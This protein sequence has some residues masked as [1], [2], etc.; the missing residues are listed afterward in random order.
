MKKI[1]LFLVLI[2]G[3]FGLNGCSDE[4]ANNRIVI[5][6][7]TGFTSIAPDS[8]IAAATKEVLRNLNAGL[9]RF[10]SEKNKLVPGLAKEYH[11]ENNGQRYIFVLRDN[12]TFHNGEKITSK[13]VKYSF[14]RIAGVTTGKPIVGDW[15]MN[16][17][18]VDIIDDKTV[19]INIKPGEEKSSDIYDL[20]DVAIIPAGSKEEDLEKHPVGAGPYK[21][22]EY[23]PGQKLVLEAF[24]NYYLGKPEIKEVE[25]RVYKEG[26]SRLMAFKSGDIDVLPL[27]FETEKELQN[28]KD[29]EIVSGLQNDVTLLYLNN[30]LEIFKNKKVRE[31]IWRSIDVDRILSGISLK[32]STKLG[33][34]MS[35]ALMEYYKKGLENKYPYTPEIGKKLLEESGVKNLKFTIKT[36]AENNYD[37]DVALF[38][39]EDLK[40]VGVDVEIEPIPLSQFLPSVFRNHEYEGAILR[41]VGYP[42]PYRILNRYRTGDISNMGEYSNPKVDQLLDEARRTYDSE[43][44]AEIYKKI[45]EILNEDIAGIYLMD[46][47]RS[48]ALSSKYTGYKMY[49]FSFIDVYSI[50]LKKTTPKK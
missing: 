8:D 42:D 1:I 10:D 11:M 9:M 6:I 15:K 7:K 19:A 46:Q 33:S 17:A 35:P 40:N 47:G 27:T 4:E 26:A 21:F 29:I 39:K 5:P 22:L 50:H 3:C 25:F 34:H 43:K 44:N 13:D 49:P 48:V 28:Q 23:I 30:S 18:S 31:G 24:D 37:N 45:Q 16:L 14:D 41:I 36:I 12:L 2:I 38:I 20:A 32:S